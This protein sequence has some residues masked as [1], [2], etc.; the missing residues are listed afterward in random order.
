MC[1]QL[2]SEVLSALVANKDRTVTDE[3]SSFNAD[4]VI[5]FQ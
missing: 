5:V 4:C 2:K 1:V 3:Q